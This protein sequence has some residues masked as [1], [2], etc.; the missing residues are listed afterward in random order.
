MF[1]ANPA[2]AVA[3]KWDETWCSI[4]V[5]IRGQ[6][7]MHVCIHVFWHKAAV[8]TAFHS[9]THQSCYSYNLLKNRR[10]QKGPQ[11]RVDSKLQQ[12]LI[13]TIT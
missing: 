3:L 2:A 6:A 12:Q 11:L 9:S 4:A 5:L 8:A 13:N 7:H 1:N 10:K